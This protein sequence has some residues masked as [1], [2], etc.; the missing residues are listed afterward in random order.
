M[1]PEKGPTFSPA[2]ASSNMKL[3]SLLA[4]SQI[5][6]LAVQRA[7]FDIWECPAPTSRPGV[8]VKESHPS[9]RSSDSMVAVASL[10]GISLI[11]LDV[12][13][14]AIFVSWMTRGNGD[15]CSG[16]LASCLQ[17]L[18][19]G[20]FNLTGILDWLMG[21]PA[22]LKLNKELAHTLGA[23]FKHHISLWQMYINYL[24]HMLEGGDMILC[25]FGYLGI[26]FLSALIVD[27]VSLFT[28]HVHCFYIYMARLYNVQLRGLLALGRFFTGKKWNPL[29]ERLDHVGSSVDQLFV[30]SLIMMV[31]V[32]LLPTTI[33][34]YFVFAALHIM[35]KIGQLPFLFMSR[36]VE[37]AAGGRKGQGF[38]STTELQKKQ[39]CEPEST[40]SFL[41]STCR[42][43]L[44][45]EII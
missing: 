29:R 25:S 30:G 38:W 5:I 44:T 14:G 6:R 33:T 1:Y 35:V 12:A 41:I 24:T 26:S 31:F 34:F 40:V 19:S 13:A 42:K 11:V 4:M 7:R 8:R 9:G 10:R 17:I 27:F 37:F 32:F 28:V 2:P 43:L 22:G 20:V 16:L 39:D 3:R 36:W 23:F 45:G 18:R 21:N 15:L